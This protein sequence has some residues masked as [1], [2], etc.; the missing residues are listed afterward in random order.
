MG[1]LVRGCGKW[2]VECGVVA[3]VSRGTL[4]L[5]SEGVCMCVQRSAYLCALPGYPGS[6]WVQCEWMDGWIGVKMSEPSSAVRRVVLAMC[7][8]RVVPLVSCTGC[9]KFAEC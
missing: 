8:R 4:I 3:A 7:A 9:L 6:V 2:G 1:R 5:Y